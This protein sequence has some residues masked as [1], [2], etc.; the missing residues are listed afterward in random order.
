MCKYK[1]STREVFTVD[2]KEIERIIQAE[3]GQKYDIWS[4]EYAHNNYNSYHVPH[5]VFDKPFLEFEQEKLNWFVA[6]GKGDYLLYVLMQDMCNKKIIPE[7][8]YLIV[9]DE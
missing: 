7:G 3:Y 4:M 2:G 8:V 5:V 6:T 9:V 1:F